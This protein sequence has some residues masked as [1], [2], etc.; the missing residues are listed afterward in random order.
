MDRQEVRQPA[1]AISKRALSYQELYT[2]VSSNLKIRAYARRDK[3]LKDKHLK[4]IILETKEKSSWAKL[5]EL[6]SH[7]SCSPIQTYC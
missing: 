4:Y 6:I 1:F 2:W 3:T 7:D 5:N